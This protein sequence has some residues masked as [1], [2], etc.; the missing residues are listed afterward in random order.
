VEKHVRAEQTLT[1]AREITADLAGRLQMPQ[2]IQISIV[3]SEKK[4]VSV[5]RIG[6]LGGADDVFTIRLDQSFL[7]GLNDEE[8]KAAIAHELGHVWISCHHPY[9]QTEA[10]ANEVALKVVSRE[11][12]KKLY[13]KLWLH[14]GTSGELDQLIG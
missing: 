12:L 3:A 7:H 6:A 4:M 9:L 5:Q 8:L 11:S 14:L 10:L 1:I 2:H 13:E